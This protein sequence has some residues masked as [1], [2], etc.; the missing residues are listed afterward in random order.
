MKK[1]I[2]LFSFVLLLTFLFGCT[3]FINDKNSGNNSN[4]NNT[5]NQDS[6]PQVLKIEDYYPIKENI[7]YVY[8]GKGN[9]YASYS[10]YIDYTSEDKVQQRVD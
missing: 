5:N 4:T 3:N 10:V 7:K 8:E 2:V 6:T 1:N 9:E